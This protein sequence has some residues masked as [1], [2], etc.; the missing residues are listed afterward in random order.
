MIALILPF[1]E[2]NLAESNLAVFSMTFLS[3]KT[4]CEILKLNRLSHV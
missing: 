2:S 1:T 3:T 4:S